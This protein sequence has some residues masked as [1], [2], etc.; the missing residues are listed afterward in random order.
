MLLLDLNFSS[1]TLIAHIDSS[2]R[3]LAVVRA[4]IFAKI[5]DGPSGHP[6]FFPTTRTQ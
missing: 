4:L 1:R 6:Q 5:I 2:W 3:L